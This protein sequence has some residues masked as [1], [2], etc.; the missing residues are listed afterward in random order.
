MFM[1][2]RYE[3]GTFTLNANLSKVFIG[4]LYSVIEKGSRPDNI[5]FIGLWI[6]LYQVA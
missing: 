1:E 2:L 5:L 6:I 3:K 4:R